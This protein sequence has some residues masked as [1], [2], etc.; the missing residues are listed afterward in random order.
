L[1]LAAAY[2]AALWISRDQPDDNV[3]G[4]FRKVVPKCILT[5]EVADLMPRSLKMPG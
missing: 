1:Q 3:T 2:H 5:E 4:A